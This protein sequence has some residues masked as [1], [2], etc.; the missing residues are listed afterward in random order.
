MKQSVI[1]YR[2]LVGDQIKIV[3][4]KNVATLNR[5][6]KQFGE[7]V[8]KVYGNTIPNFSKIDK[9]SIAIKMTAETEPLVLKVNDTLTK[10]LFQEVVASM[11]AAGRGL[12]EIKDQVDNVVREVRI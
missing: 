7:N 12:M 10:Q 8:G 11:K 3:G 1:K 2:R 5:I 9:D 4:F 6:E